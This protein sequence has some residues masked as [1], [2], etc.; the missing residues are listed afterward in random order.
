LGATLTL[1]GGLALPAL[2]RAE[3]EPRIVRDEHVPL[4]GRF[5]VPIVVEAKP[6]TTVSIVPLRYDHD[7]EAEIEAAGVE[8][9]GPCTVQLPAGEYRV[10][11][12]ENGGEGATRTLRL[13]EPERLRIGPA[14]N[15]PSYACLALGIA[16]SLMIP[17]GVIV[18]VSGRDGKLDT[19]MDTVSEENQIAGLS[20][21]GA[22]AALTVAG[23]VLYSKS[24]RFE[25]ERSPLWQ[26][27]PVPSV[28]FDF[29]IGPKRAQL[30]A[31]FAF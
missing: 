27:T 23:F 28:S 24:L 26:P 1:L 11:T 4:H 19:S 9:E 12:L 16:G 17:V 8:C 3:D 21:A 14:S 13:R 25:L 31:T 30:G 18:M 7:P 6:T 2:A 10:T 5:Y 15:L 22:G 29:D 20:I